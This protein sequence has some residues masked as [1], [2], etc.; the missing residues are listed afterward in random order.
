M[1]DNNTV[2]LGAIDADRGIENYGMMYTATICHATHLN[3]ASDL[4]GLKITSGDFHTFKIP[5]HF[6]LQF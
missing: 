1:F 5:R 6:L 3:P 2:T 4:V